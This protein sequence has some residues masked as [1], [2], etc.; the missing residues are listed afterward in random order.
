MGGCRMWWGVR[1]AGI[2][3]GGD[4]LSFVE[5]ASVKLIRGGGGGGGRIRRGARRAV[6]VRV[7]GRAAWVAV[8][9]AESADGQTRCGT[10]ARR[11]WT[12]RAWGRST[13][14]GRMRGACSTRPR[15]NAEALGGVPVA[16]ADG[17]DYPPAWKSP[18]DSGVAV[19]DFNA[20]DHP[21]RPRQQTGTPPAPRI[22]R[23][24]VLHAPRHPSSTSARPTPG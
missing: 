14:T 7:S 16:G 22:R 4:F 11:G 24:R 2:E 18:R 10:R 5:D 3:R 23:G 17:G 15:R 6:V 8:V 9:R 19:A 1:W 13:R 21:L 20:G 12:I